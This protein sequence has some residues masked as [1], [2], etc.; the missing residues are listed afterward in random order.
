M[1][2]KLQPK[3]YFSII[4]VPDQDGDPRNLL[5]SYGQGKLL[6]V[7]LIVLGLHAIIGV[8][9]Y[10]YIGSLRG[11]RS[12]LKEN[13][14]ALEVRNKKIESI[15]AEFEKIKS[16]D[17]KIRTAFGSTLGLEPQIPEDW[18]EMATRAQGA[19]P[20]QNEDMGTR[21]QQPELSEHRTRDGLY[22]LADKKG[23]YS[24]PEYFP[25][26]LPVGGYL[27]TH[28]QKGGWYVGRSHYGIDIAASKGSVIRAAGAGIVIFSDWTP[29]LGNMVVL[30]HGN[31]LYSYYGHAMH[32]LVEQGAFIR[33]GQPLALLGSSGIS[34]APH[35]H[36]EIWKNGEP[37]DPEDF[38]FALQQRQDEGSL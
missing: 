6:L 21:T 13:V 37:L 22:F 33:K 15:Y 28:F 24:G 11:Q 18:A 19:L 30:S 2:K 38:L 17:Q 4:F 36:F 9:G 3:R 7:A 5:L 32:L 31:G 14:R 20:V 26:L 1:M 25:T 12:E 16:I 34:S 8:A 10:F 23:I 29:D 27:T 35:L